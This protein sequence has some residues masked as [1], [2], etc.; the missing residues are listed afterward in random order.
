MHVVTNWSSRILAHDARLP[1]DELGGQ[2]GLVPSPGEVILRLPVAVRRPQLLKAVESVR[3]IGESPLAVERLDVAILRA[4][5]RGTGR[6]YPVVEQL[7]PRLVVDLVADDR[8]MV[9]VATDDGPNDAF[10][11]GPELG[12]RVV[13]LLPPAPRTAYAGRTGRRCPGASSAATEEP[14]VGVPRITEMSCACA[15]SSTGCSQSR[16]NSP[17]AAPRLTTRIR[18]RGSR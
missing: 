17:S 13:D 12:M 6:N 9:D 16:S 14:R 4:A 11:V 1:G 7:E 2:L 15:A 5:G 8:R 10:G 3:P 18:R